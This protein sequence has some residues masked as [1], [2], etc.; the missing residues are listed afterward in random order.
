MCRCKTIKLLCPVS[1]IIDRSL[2]PARA[3]VVATPARKL[4]LEYWCGF[5]GSKTVSHE[6]DNFSAL[7]R[8]VVTVSR[9]I[10]LQSEATLT[11]LDIY[12]SESIILTRLHIPT[13]TA[14]NHMISSFL[15]PLLLSLD[16]DNSVGEVYEVCDWRHKPEKSP[17]IWCIKCKDF[18]DIKKCKRVMRTVFA[19][20]HVGLFPYGL[21]HKH[22]N[23]D[24]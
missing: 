18:R 22:N 2:A 13:A 8:R 21:C 16:V 17:V 7:N 12:R 11:H 20:T 4:C 10:F 1:S 5:C 6:S 9:N 19:V 14:I 3:T 23:N 24:E 15:L